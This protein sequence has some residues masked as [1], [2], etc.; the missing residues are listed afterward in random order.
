MTQDLIIEKLNKESKFLNYEVDQ[1]L[2]DC[3]ISNNIKQDIKV[4]LS[5][6]SKIEPYKESPGNYKNINLREIVQINNLTQQEKFMYSIKSFYSYNLELYDLELP[7]LYDDFEYN[8]LI[9]QLNNNYFI[10]GR[11]GINEVGTEI[12]SFHYYNDLK[13]ISINEIEEPFKKLLS[14]I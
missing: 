13:I 14:N 6:N 5:F 2:T 12:P 7:I 4:Y 1:I 10:I 9:I 11:Y 8:Y 3:K